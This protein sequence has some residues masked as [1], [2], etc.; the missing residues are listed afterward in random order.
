MFVNL[1]ENDK[2]LGYGF[3]QVPGIASANKK[4]KME[5]FKGNV[6]I[7]PDKTWAN[8]DVFNNL[9]EKWVYSVKS[10]LR[11]EAKNLAEID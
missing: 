3:T 4:D 2:I 5:R 10:V 9:C 6:F 8:E 11:G 1:A 7:L